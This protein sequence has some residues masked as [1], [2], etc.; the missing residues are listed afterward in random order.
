MLNLL[1][2][3]SYYAVISYY[4]DLN[5]ILLLIR[6]NQLKALLKFL[7]WRVFFLISEAARSA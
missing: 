4:H 5:L 2:M 6:E 1:S 7:D 3:L